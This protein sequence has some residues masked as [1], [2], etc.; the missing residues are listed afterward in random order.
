[1]RNF[2]ITKI[3]KK[4][5][6]LWK[7]IYP[8]AAFAFGLNQFGGEMWLPSKQNKAKALK[9]IESIKQVDKK[10]FDALKFLESHRENILF[11]EPTNAPQQISNS[12][13]EH[14]LIE[15]H[16]RHT[17]ALAKA[18]IKLIEIEEKIWNK[19]W[20]LEIK[21][22]TA[23]ECNAVLKLIESAK[24]Y[25]KSEALNLLENKIKFWLVKCGCKL[26][27]CDFND[28]FPLLKKDGEG[29]GRE[30]IYPKLLKSLY[31]FEESP[32]EIESLA[33]K[34]LHQE[35]KVFNS[36]I[37]YLSKKFKCKPKLKEIIKKGKKLFLI[38]KEELIAVVKKIREILKKIAEKELIKIT[39][40]YDVRIVETPKY[41]VPFMPTAAMQAF[42]A[43]KKPWCAFFVTTDQRGSPSNTLPQIVQTI[44]H[45]EYG[46]CVNFLNT[47][48]AFVVKPRLIH[49][50]SN[51][52]DVP[53]TEGLS[54][55]REKEALEI[56]E[57]LAEQS[58]KDYYLE[59]EKFV[60]KYGSMKDFIQFLHLVVS[61]WRIL[62][63]LRAICDVRVNTGKQ[64]FDA[65]VEWAS[66]ETNLDPKLIYNQ[67]F[68]FQKMPGY[69]PCYSIFGQRLCEL[70][71]KALKK[72]IERVEFNTFVASIG[73][74]PRT[75]F[76]K[77]IKKRFF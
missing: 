48:N 10:D 30:K 71:K 17:L 45:E 13:Y 14:A 43:F 7:E 46:H 58:A 6:S 59:F 34:W 51:N 74:P 66:L 72:G 53:I 31:D 19:S 1:M 39:P 56:F 35:L 4:I 62:R 38:K 8:T 77:I 70:Q 26:R 63:F 41:L 9:A 18:G 54:F 16:D 47:F 64:R 60:R 11:E 57:I 23:L 29:F 40:K 27:R 42:N 61:E 3:D 52:L 21:I 28:I 24:N 69:A 32:K 33:L 15:G 5:F 37:D 12:I 55:H 36:T 67:T 25:I 76:E 68:F 73:F 2:Q 75:S 65:F 50:L 20:P 44:V 22:L 49:V